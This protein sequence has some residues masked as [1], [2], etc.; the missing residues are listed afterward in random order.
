[1][2]IS[3]MGHFDLPSL[4]ALNRIVS[5]APNHAYSIFLSGAQASTKDV[6]E[7]LQLLAAI[8]RSL[9]KRFLEDGQTS[10]ILKKTKDL[11][12]PN[13]AEGLELLRSADPDLIVSIRYRR[14]LKEAAIA[15]PKNGVLNLHSGILPDYRGVMATFWA[16]LNGER[17]IGCT[18][19]R[20]VDSG[21]DTG[22]IIN[23][24]RQPLQAGATYLANVLRL[25][26]PGCDAMLA[27]IAEIGAGREPAA[28]PQIAGSGRYFSTPE[29]PDLARFHGQGGILADGAELDSL[30]PT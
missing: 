1:M 12:A 24:A 3:L 28:R 25:Y 15:I 16:M 26:R 5:G 18:L 19:H 8:D 23:I 14:I 29:A 2:K 20:I 10:P 7:A 22:P 13:S 4:T 30:S 6:P 27:A 9:S 11:P 17:E 21:I